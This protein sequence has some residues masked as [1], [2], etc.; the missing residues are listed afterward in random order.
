MEE[1]DWTGWTGTLLEKLIQS[2]AY[3]NLPRVDLHSRG[4]RLSA[5]IQSV[6]AADYVRNLREEAKKGIYGRLKQGF[7]PMRAPI[8]C[9]ILPA[10][11][12]TANSLTD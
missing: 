9:S 2:T 10:G 7:Y 6:V 1:E 11:A 5:D 8:G 12:L 3:G 4:G